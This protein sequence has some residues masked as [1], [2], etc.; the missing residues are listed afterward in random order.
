MIHYIRFCTLTSYGIVLYLYIYIAL[1]TVYTNQK[2]SSARDPERRE[3]PLLFRTT[4]LVTQVKNAR[5]LINWIYINCEMTPRR[6]SPATRSRT[7]E[8]ILNIWL[9]GWCM[10]VTIVFFCCFDSFV[11][12]DIR[13]CAV[14]KSKPEVGS[15]VKSG[16]TDYIKYRKKIL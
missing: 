8:N 14:A 2:R 11:N 5:D 13:S 1:H 12:E 6:T 9:D 7:L 4:P 10:V 3:H 15:C 16:A